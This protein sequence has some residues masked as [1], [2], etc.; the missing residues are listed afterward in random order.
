MTFCLWSRGVE[1]LVDAVTMALT[2]QIK[3]YANLL[4]DIAVR[5][6]NAFA[7]TAAVT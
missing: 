6:A 7:V 2:G 1:L 5:Y 4:C 3:I